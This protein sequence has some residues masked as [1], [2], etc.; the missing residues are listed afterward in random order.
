LYLINAG[1][2]QPLDDYCCAIRN[3]LH[4]FTADMEGD[5]ETWMISPENFPLSPH[6]SVNAAEWANQS[7]EAAEKLIYDIKI[8]PREFKSR[9][10]WKPKEMTGALSP[11]PKN[12]GVD[13]VAVNVAD[14]NV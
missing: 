11:V 6:S 10:D 8:K 4:L 2:L 3:E 12:E 1:L 9:K 14:E 5:S 7:M 13:N